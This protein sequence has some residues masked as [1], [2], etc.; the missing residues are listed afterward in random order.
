MSDEVV[1]VTLAPGLGLEEKSGGGQ[2]GTLAVACFWIDG[3]GF[4]RETLWLQAGDR[5][6]RAKELFPLPLTPV[7][8]TNLFL[9]K[10]RSIFFKLCCLAPL[11][12]ILFSFKLSIF[13]LGI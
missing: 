5:R 10:D 11:I 1:T 9:G 13:F 8:T 3:D 4:R 2:E 12:T 7:K 6:F